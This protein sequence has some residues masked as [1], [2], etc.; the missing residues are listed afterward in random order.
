MHKV[1]VVEGILGEITVLVI[2]YQA[3]PQERGFE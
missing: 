3:Y 1:L 2:E